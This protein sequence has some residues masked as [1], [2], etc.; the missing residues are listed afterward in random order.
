MINTLAERLRTQPPIDQ[1]G[2][3]HDLRFEAANEIDRLRT[4]LEAVAAP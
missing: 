1:T 2:D 4:A 3:T